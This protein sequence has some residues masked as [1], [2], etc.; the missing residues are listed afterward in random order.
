MTWK[1]NFVTVLTPVV[2]SILWGFTCNVSQINDLH[3]RKVNPTMAFKFEKYDSAEEALNDL[4]LILPK[5]TP[6][7]RIQQVMLDVG[8]TT[9]DVRSNVLPARF[10]EPST[11]LVHVVWSLAFYLDSEQKLD[12]II[13]NRGL[14]GP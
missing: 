10:V 12:H 11:T 13:L 3:S 1:S 14:T 7:A 5:G 4:Q 2:I 8:A 9:Y 6:L